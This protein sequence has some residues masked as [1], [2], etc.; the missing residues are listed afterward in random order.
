MISFAVNA[1]DHI[2]DDDMALVADAA[3]A[4]VQEIINSGQYVLAGALDEGDSSV[5]DSNGIVTNGP[6]L[7]E[8][9]DLT[10]VDVPSRRGPRGGGQNRD[11]VSLRT[12]SQRNQP[13]PPTRRN[14]QLTH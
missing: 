5:V 9:S 6:A 11:C 1:M 13:R 12:G 8:V 4:V 10:I 14:D 2:S 3:H 7:R